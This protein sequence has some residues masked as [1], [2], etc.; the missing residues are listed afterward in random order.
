MTP[1]QLAVLALPL[2]LTAPAP[3]P[4]GDRVAS[5]SRLPEGDLLVVHYESSGCFHSEGWRFLL[6]GGSTPSFA[7]KEVGSRWRGPDSSLE[8]PTPTPLTKQQVGQIDGELEFWRS[9]HDG[10]CTTTDTI[11]VAQ[12]RAGAVLAREHFVDSTCSEGVFSLPGFAWRIR[13]QHLAP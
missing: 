9:K 13:F 1:R 11:D 8:Y 4:V 2:C 10:G 6:R 7:F 12:L 3:R 5:L